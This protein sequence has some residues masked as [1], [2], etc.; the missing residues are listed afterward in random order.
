MAVRAPAWD[1]LGRKDS[2]TC[3][4]RSMCARS[5]LHGARPALLAVFSHSA[6]SIVSSTPSVLEKV[7]PAH[8]PQKETPTI[9]SPFPEPPVTTV[10]FLVAYSG[11]FIEME[12][13]ITWP[14]A[15]GVLL[16]F[17]GS[18]WWECLGALSL[19]GSTAFPEP[20]TPQQLVLVMCSLVQVLPPA[21][22]S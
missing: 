2:E 11:R 15:S 6:L 4:C 21:R 5:H 13:D 17:Q 22:S 18:S 8:P 3:G 14:S 16:C 20:L 10:H 1:V 12:S 19:S 9:T 7:T